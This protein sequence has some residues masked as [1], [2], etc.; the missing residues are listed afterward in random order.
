MGILQNNFT[1]LNW[2]QK[3]TELF[4][5]FTQLKLNQNEA[6]NLNNSITSKEKLTDK[7]EK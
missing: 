4:L 3:K 6:N 1:L 5:Q 2:T 7:A